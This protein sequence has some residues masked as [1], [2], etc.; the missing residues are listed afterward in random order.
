MNA[1]SQKKSLYLS[2][3][4]MARDDE[5]CYF[6]FKNFRIIFVLLYCGEES[7]Y[8]GI[9]GQNR[10]MSNLLCQFVAKKA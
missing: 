2:V 4:L 10:V 7:G 1:L 8:F 9:V 5:F 6:S 3:F